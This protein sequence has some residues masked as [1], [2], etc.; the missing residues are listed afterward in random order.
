MIET[1]QKLTPEQEDLLRKLAATEKVSVKP[2]KGTFFEK[3]KELF[4]ED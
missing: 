2:H 3:L 1:P 4:V